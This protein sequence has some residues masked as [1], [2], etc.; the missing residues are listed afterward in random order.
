LLKSLFYSIFAWLI[1]IGLY[2]LIRFY[3][4]TEVVDWAP[5]TKSIVVVW[6][7]ASLIF[8][9]IYW[10][11]TEISDRP[12]FR[13][14]SYGFL[15]SFRIAG[16][17]SGLLL[18][19]L[20]T[21]IWAF[22][23]GDIVLSQVLPSYWERLTDKPIRAVFAYL[24]VVSAIFAFIRQMVNMV[25]GR[26]LGNLMLGKYHN[27]KEEER[28]FMF[29]DLK[30]STTYAEKLGNTRFCRLIQDCFHD[31]TDSAIK[32]NVEIYQ[33]V[34]DEAILTWTIDDGTKNS[35]CVNV[36]F[37]F[38]KELDRKS[39]YYKKEYDLEPLFKAG[40]NTGP[41]TVAQVGDI[42]RDI[43]YLSDVLNTAARIQDKCNE[44]GKHLLIAGPVKNIL[45]K[46]ESLLLKHIG[47]IEL[48]GKSE[49][50]DI[51]SVDEI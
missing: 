35:N 19:G 22:W 30:S 21:R 49:E 24:V 16:V 23:N 11:T 26:V 44:Y 9:I 40:V 1:A 18:I 15:I 7:I 2:M 51:Y 42:K 29:L 27:P 36:Y 39:E 3:G 13:K 14:R 48:R 33:Y 28:I 31:L 46:N 32:H 47:K 4:T 17:I 41:V 50:V 5:D 37:D 25:G 20:F 12:V 10:I 34:G 8:G 45:P 6:I 43:A 38:Q